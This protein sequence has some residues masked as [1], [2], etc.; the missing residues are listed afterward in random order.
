MQKAKNIALTVEGMNCTNCALGIKKNLDKNGFQD[1]Y[2]NFSA[3]EV[4]F[5]Y[6][7]AEEKEN[8][9]KQISAMGYKVTEDNEELEPKKPKLSA[10]EK[11]FYFTIIFTI[12]LLTA[13]FLPFEILHNPFF[14]LALTL[15]V[16]IVGLFHFG[17]SAFHSVKSGIPNMDVLI[18]LGST[19]AF[20][21]SFIGT[22]Y[23]LGHDYQFYETTASIISL[24][25]LGNLLEHKAIK[26]TTSAIEDLVKLQKIIAKKIV[27]NA[28]GKEIIIETEAKK[29]KI[30]DILLIN[31]GDKIPIDGIIIWG[32]GSIDESMISGESLPIEKDIENTVIGGTV[33]SSGSI[34]IKATAVGNETVL[35]KIIDFVKNVNQD[36]PQ[37]QN[38]ADKISAI[39]VPV[40]IL[41]SFLTFS[42]SWGIFNLTFQEALMRSI[43]ILVIACPCALGLAIPTAV[44]VGVGRVSKIGILIKGASTIQ[45][46]LN[47]KFIVFDKTGTLTTGNFKIKEIK[48]FDKDETEVKSIIVGLEKHSSH[49]IA[50]SILHEMK[51]ISEKEFTSVTENKGIG[52]LGKDSFGNIYEIGSYKIAKDFTNETNG[53]AYLL[54]NNKL[55]AIVY[56]QDEIK[57][58]AKKAIEFFKS[59]GVKTILL[60]GDNEE[61]CNDLSNIL[62]INDVYFEKQPLEKLQIISELKKHGEI[63]MVG[64]GINDA[65][66]LAK[67]D[68]AI[69]LSN[70]TDIAIQSSQIILLKGNLELLSKAYLISKNTMII[71]KQ[72]LFW[73]FFYNIIAIPLAAT[74]MLNPMIAAASMALSDVFVVLNSLRLQYKKLD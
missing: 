25:L 34:K 63:A 31:S 57:P 44:V 43:A 11:K 21:Y 70:A 69:S 73:A 62:G 13:M 28:D 55:I 37:I 2:V 6:E 64:D 1:V 48:C 68:I 12:P 72:N 39:F 61:K 47:V 22:I 27:I 18:I 20:I 35:A 45:K 3:N 7:T 26:K 4:S 51:N 15:P 58:E 30:N 10:I 41:I 24:I 38:L 67:A 23:S 5:S 8:A 74:G 66:A 56:L 42:V 9:I 36:K 19:A 50:S 32:N 52:I 60:S 40:V 49:P 71:I 17:K 53:N 46:L 16:F 14:Q 54:E 59:Q 65:P 29:I 33:L